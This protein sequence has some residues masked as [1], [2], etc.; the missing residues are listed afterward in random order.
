LT[1]VVIQEPSQAVVEGDEL[2]MQQQTPKI[3]DK[4]T[5][6]I[7]VQ[8]VPKVLEGTTVA[9]PDNRFWV[10]NDSIAVAEEAIQR[11]GVLA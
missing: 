6:A 11:V 3:E 4:R 1:Q 2:A 10:V 8:P 5:D 9:V 7:P